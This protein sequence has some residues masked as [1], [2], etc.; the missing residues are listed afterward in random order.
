MQHRK[1]MEEN[2][3]LGTEAINLKKSTQPLCVYL[4][5]TNIRLF[6][7]ISMGLSREFDVTCG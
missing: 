2:N 6:A 1:N 4:P 5:L 7:E 3:M